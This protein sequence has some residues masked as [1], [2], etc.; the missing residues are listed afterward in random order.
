MRKILIK[1]FDRLEDRVR[2]HLSHRAIFY[3]LIGGMATVL[4]WRGIWHTA[5]MLEKSNDSSGILAILFSGPVSLIMSIVILLLT[6]LFVSVFIGDKIII[7]G[8]KQEKK[9]FD[10]TESEVKEE[11]DMLFQ[12][13]SSLE[14]LRQE[15]RDINTHTG[16]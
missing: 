13:K 7:S 11:G 8:L 9:V 6:G 16:N 12:I 15:V 5:D 10:K 2:I 1:F 3:A 14:Q 4:F